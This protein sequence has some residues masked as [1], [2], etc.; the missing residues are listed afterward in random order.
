MIYYVGKE[1]KW[2]NNCSD[3]ADAIDILKS[4][5]KITLWCTGIQE[6]KKRDR[7]ESDSDDDISVNPSKRTRISSFKSKPLAKE[8]ECDT[9][10][11]ELRQLHGTAY[12]AVQK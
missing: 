8:T 12:S 7:K 3:A 2:I 10:V 5:K 11:S 4:Q 1:K 9:I 6:K